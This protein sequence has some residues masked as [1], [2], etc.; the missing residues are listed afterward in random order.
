MKARDYFEKYD[1][2]IM[3][4]QKKKNGEIGTTK[5]LLLE[6]SDEVTAVCKQQKA[7]KDEAV[8]AV[9][10][11]LNQKWNAICRMYEKKYGVSPL[12][13]DAFRCYWMTAMP[14]LAG[15]L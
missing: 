1:I 4:E 11:E 2:L 6:M 15:K 8:I 3:E 10:K 14:E 7:V 5:K 13:Y 9:L 12:N